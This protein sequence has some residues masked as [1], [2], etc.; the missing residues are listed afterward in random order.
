MHQFFA[1]RRSATTVD[2]LC[3]NSSIQSVNKVRRE[4]LQQ[5]IDA[6]RRRDMLQQEHLKC[7]LAKSQQAKWISE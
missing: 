3:C 4:F 1:N 7:Q 6:S 2:E 5:E